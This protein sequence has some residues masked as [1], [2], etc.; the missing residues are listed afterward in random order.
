VRQ[1]IAV[2]HIGKIRTRRDANEPE[3]MEALR[4]AGA[5]PMQFDKPADLLVGFRQKWIWL[6]VKDGS[7]P[8]SRQ[9]LTDDEVEF[10]RVCQIE[11][12]PFDVVTTPMEA[13][14]AIGAIE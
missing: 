9:K 7:K 8:P 3:I 6:E 11:R 1:E 12:L 2:R 10:A 4:K 14:K 5:W 13:L